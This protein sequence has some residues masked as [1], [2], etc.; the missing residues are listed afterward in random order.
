MAGGA[1]T[2]A[3]A[4]DHV[5]VKLIRCVAAAL[6]LLALGARPATAMPEVPEARMAYHLY[7][8]VMDDDGGPGTTD[9]A[10]RETVR[11]AGALVSQASGGRLMPVTVTLEH[12]TSS[13]AAKSG[14]NCL[15][16]AAGKCLAEVA[17][18]VFPRVPGRG[19]DIV[20]WQPARAVAAMRVRSW[21]GDAVV[22]PGDGHE[23]TASI[24]AAL[25][26]LTTAYSEFVA[27]PSA[28]PS[29]CA[30]SY[31]GTPFANT[32]GN[33]RCMGQGCGGGGSV[34]AWAAAGEAERWQNGLTEPGEIRDLA[35][36]A[37]SPAITATVTLRPV[38][39]EAGVRALRVTDPNTG[40][41]YY[42]QYRSGT[43]ADAGAAYADP[44]AT[45]ATPGY[46]SIDFTVHG[47]T[48]LVVE[49]AY[50][51]DNA[52]GRI[53]SPGYYT[54]TVTDP[55]DDEYG[56]ERAIFAPGETYRSADGTITATVDSADPATGLQV[57]VTL[58]SSLPPIT[59][60]LPRWTWHGAAVV[61]GAPHVVRSGAMPKGATV[62][63]SA[64]EG[65][66]ADLG[67][68][69]PM[70]MPGLDHEAFPRVADLGRRLVWRTVVRMPGHRAAV[71]TATSGKVRMPELTICWDDC[72]GVVG[73]DV[74]A[75]V[76]SLT[77][78]EIDQNP[79][80]HVTWAWLRDGH[81]IA[82]AKQ[83]IYRTTP[84]DTGHRLAARETIVLAGHRWVLT[85]KSYPV[86]AV[87]S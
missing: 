28:T 39:S 69:P 8:A 35:L 58:Q 87:P 51:R 25:A 82:G 45:W 71:R 27:C 22:A 59:A 15:G 2:R 37:S 40:A 43:G 83:F 67:D 85:S 36:P 63:T 14:Y 73:G 65:S 68:S 49:G 3:E 10:I 64:C 9:A 7:V 54:S 32:L 56:T 16:K 60:A 5:P 53:G 76:G 62:V 17:G 1:Q 30:T 75:G 34:S 33:G 24:A 46:R 18:R 55:D 66:C 12:Y 21:E 20:L 78:G 29:Q 57:T 81:V 31:D 72:G 19:A 38:G 79:A 44:E 77:A 61:G 4:P 80:V 13:V 74:W 11:A 52:F 42:L 70:L 50:S 84:A 6:V 86:V 23:L 41:R 48:G 47:G 26:P